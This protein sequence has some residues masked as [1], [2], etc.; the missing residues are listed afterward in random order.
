[1]NKTK[2]KKFKKFM[3]YNKY[4]EWENT[5]EVYGA[6][7]IYKKTIPKLKKIKLLLNLVSYKDVLEVIVDDYIKNN[8]KEINKLEELL[9]ALKHLE[10]FEN[11][12]EKK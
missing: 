2:I 6:I 12:M 11:L 4:K 1:M 9:K 10:V 5:D 8:K 3:D 7:T